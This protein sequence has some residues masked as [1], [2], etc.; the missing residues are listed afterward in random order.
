MIKWVRKQWGM[1]FGS[2]R[3]PTVVLA[4]I[5]VALATLD[6]FARAYVAV[7]PRSR[8]FTIPRDMPMP[9][10]AD[11]GD[12]QSFVASWIPPRVEEKAEVPER[13]IKL[14][15]V[16]FARGERTAA[17][18]LAPSSGEA[19][20][21]WRAKLGD[22]REGWTVERIDANLVILRRGEESKEL[23]LFSLPEGI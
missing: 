13:V 8:E 21:R 3:Q 15:G 17:M 11:S 14:Q 19:P 9:P 18:L 2:Y 12:I 16:F 6:F 20:E 7:D 1:L 4:L 10:V 22:S 23:R 5:L